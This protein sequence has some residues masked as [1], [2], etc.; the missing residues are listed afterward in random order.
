MCGLHFGLA[1]FA[2]AVGIHLGETVGLLGR[3]VLGID[4]AIAIGVHPFEHL[5]RVGG[6]FCS[7]DH[8]IAVGVRVL[9]AERAGSNGN[10]A[11]QRKRRGGKGQSQ[12]T[13]QSLQSKSRLSCDDTFGGRGT[14]VASPQLVIPYLG[15]DCRSNM[16]FW[17][18]IVAICITRSA[19]FT[20]AK[21][22][23]GRCCV[24]SPAVM[25]IAVACPVTSAVC[26]TP[27]GLTA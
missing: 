17:A 20:S 12:F 23:R 4:R 1:D 16:P 19:P 15:G 25:K 10:T 8:A 7:C 5:G 6:M 27:G 11:C 22:H 9:L 21:S 13:H 3:A 18:R 26:Q 24:P 2:I 14:G